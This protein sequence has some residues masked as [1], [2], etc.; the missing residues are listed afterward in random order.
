MDANL[1]HV[2]LVI[3]N[4]RRFKQRFKLFEE[5]VKHLNTFGVQ[6]HVVE[7]A[8]GERSWHLA[9]K[10][11][12]NVDYIP[13]RT[14]H[15][16]WMKENLI[17]VGVSHL[18][19]DW[20]YVAWIDGDV[21][22]VN[23]NWAVEAVH[24]LQHHPVI[25][26]FSHVVDVGPNY[27]A[28]IDVTGDKGPTMIG[29][30]FCYSYVNDLKEPE[31]CKEYGGKNFWHPGFA[32]ACTR[33]AW[34][35][36]GGLIDKSICGAGDHHMAWALIGQVNRACHGGMPKSF[37]DYIHTW[38][39]HA[40]ALHGQLGYVPGTIIHHWHGKR[41]NRKYRERWKMLVEAKFNPYVDVKYDSQGV[42]QL[43]ESNSKLMRDLQ[44]YFQQRNEDSI[45]V[46]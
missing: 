12:A 10:L 15:E 27:E 8:F 30:S 16:L 26:L 18:P 28:V 39:K 38:Q 32:W 6:L 31:D 1:L 24:M 19:H 42:L 37:V 14:K 13:V 5:S 9:D 3:S 29:N 22:F 43:A 17:N 40:E 41:T 4:P 33:D 23:P 21:Q 7:C 35:T 44:I 46:E 36:F 25:Q 45:D 11:P 2:V 34:N 20:K